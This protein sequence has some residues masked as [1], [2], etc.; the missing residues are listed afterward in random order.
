VGGEGKKSGRPRVHQG[1]IQLTTDPFAFGCDL[2]ARFLTKFHHKPNEFERAEQTVIVLVVDDDVVIR[3]QKL[4]ADIRES[5]LVNLILL[6]HIN[7]YV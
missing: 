2:F 4:L 7:D 5:F 3:R 6:R 1:A